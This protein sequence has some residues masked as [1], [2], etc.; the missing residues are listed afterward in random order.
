MVGIA[1]TVVGIMVVLYSIAM[2]AASVH[3]P[4]YGFRAE[5]DRKVRALEAEADRMERRER[6]QPLKKPEPILTADGIFIPGLTPLE[7]EL[8][9]KQP[10]QWAEEAASKVQTEARRAYGHANNKPGYPNYRDGQW[11]E[12]RAQLVADG[13]EQWLLWMERDTKE[14]R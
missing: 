4:K 5:I 7:R 13:H 14:D 1:V 6:I 2:I 10:A 3:S 8:L 12:F 11:A 9:G